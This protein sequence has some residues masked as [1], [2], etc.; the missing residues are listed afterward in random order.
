MR[1]P[2]DCR[3]RIRRSRACPCGS[4]DHE[5][6]EKAVVSVLST[7]AQA[8]AAESVT[9]WQAVLSRVEPGAHVAVVASAGRYHRVAAAAEAAGFE[10]RDCVA[11]ARQGGQALALVARRPLDRSSLA[12]SLVAG[13]C[14][15]L[16]VD[17][18]RIV[19]GEGSE[20][21]RWPPNY[22]V[23][24]LP[25][26]VPGGSK[27]VRAPV[28]N[29]W[30]DGAKPFGDGAGGSYT[31]ETLGDSDGMERVDVWRCAAKC[32]VAEMDRQ[33]G[34]SADGVGPSRFFLRTSGPDGFAE[35]LA[36]LVAVPG[37]AV[38]DAFSDLSSS[39]G[40]AGRPP[41]GSA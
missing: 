12:A 29:R 22:A 28:I 35:W 25:D 39:D 1:R 26:C 15:G 32:P 33:A 13:G 8:R 10:V 5:R 4:G 2:V 38:W 34:T 9:V 16:R 6:V 31:T 41:G 40:H 20:Y 17:D 37:S 24:H 11:C 18:G 23:A 30:D 36:V 19:A 3:A 27:R 7:A 14:G 21:G